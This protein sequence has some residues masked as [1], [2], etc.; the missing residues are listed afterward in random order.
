MFR[1]YDA[2]F[3]AGSLDEAFLDVTGFCR[4]HG[5]SGSQVR[6]CVCVCVGVC[7]YACVWVG[8]CGG[9]VLWA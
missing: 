2:H 5:V 6:V 8:V 7:G 1:R 9:G 3:E 4:S